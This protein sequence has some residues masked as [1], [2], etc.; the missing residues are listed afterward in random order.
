MVG[1]VWSD[2]KQYWRFYLVRGVLLQLLVAGLGQLVLAEAFQ[3]FLVLANQ[4]QLT[5]TNLSQV[6][7]NPLGILG[8]IGYV[9]ILLFL[10]FLEF[11]GLAT[12]IHRKNRRLTWSWASW[13]PIWR[14]FW[15]RVSGWQM[16]PFAAYLLLSIP[17]VQWLLPSV[18]LKRLYIPH[19]ITDELRKQPLTAGLLG[20]VLS[21]CY[22]VNLRLIY[23]LPLLVLEQGQAFWENMKLSWY[24]TRGKTLLLLRT[25]LLLVFPLVM[26]IGLLGIG[27]LFGLDWLGQAGFSQLA[28]LGLLAVVFGVFFALTTLIRLVLLTFLLKAVGAGQLLPAYRGLPVVSNLSWFVLLGLVFT[29][30][31]GQF[32]QVYEGLAYVPYNQ[33]V[34]TIA[35]RGDVTRGV[36]NSLEALEAAAQ[37][38]ADY[39]EMDIILTK[40]GHFVVSHDNNLK[41]LTG[42][43]R[44]ISRSSRDE[45]VGLPISQ[46]GHTSQLVAFETYVERAKQLGVKLMVELKPHGDEPDDY[47]QRAVA[48]LRELGV[49]RSYKI[50]SLD[51]ELMRAIEGLAPELETGYVIPFQFGYLAGEG[52]DFLLVED[53]SY[54]D[55][56]V[57]EAQWRGQELYVWTI[58]REDQ[59]IRY[60]NS[61]VAGLITDELGLVSEV[62]AELSAETSL[63]QRLL[64]LL[65]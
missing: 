12:I 53:F 4:E 47:A 31:L 29:L 11:L 39:V 6:I 60:F 9:L 42:Q 32:A 20:L 33:E 14:Q 23:S 49:S 35:H 64:R 28:Q 63:S 2:I 46:N 16:L 44:E 26:L 24:L 37:V 65:N 51:L 50:M 38:G 7:L 13:R 59:L 45:L 36:E 54:R 34:Q 48:A 30:G 10:I 27:L 8:I 58:N 25:L 62:K 17:T 57:W 61:P 41:R 3:L 43:K 15:Q 1:S 5:A 22:Y 40:D 21:L 18:L 56:L 19:F 52:V 55:R